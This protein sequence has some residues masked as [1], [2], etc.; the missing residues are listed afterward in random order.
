MID[1]KLCYQLVEPYLGSTFSN[2]RTST[3]VLYNEYFNIYFITWLSIKNE[4]ILI[5][6]QVSCV[7]LSSF[8][9]YCCG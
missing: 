9:L 6:Y 8:F 4:I 5:I 1:M 7:G 3:K 2:S